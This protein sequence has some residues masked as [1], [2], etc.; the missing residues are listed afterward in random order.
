MS[1]NYVMIGTNDL[2]RAKAFY[3]AVFPLI[4][5]TLE[6]DYPGFACCFRFRNGT[7]AWIAPPH[8]KHAAAPGNGNMPG[9]GCT[10]SAEVDAA[11]AAALAAGGS[12]EGA[13]GPRPQYGPDFYG[14][15]VRDLDGNKLS[16]IVA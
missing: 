10:S 8:D 7:R 1:I 12:D 11:H 5:G 9:Y 16:F 4:G 3:G 15:Y 13:P 6:A 14:A 2:P